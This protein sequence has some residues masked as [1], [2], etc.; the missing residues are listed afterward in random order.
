M[1]VK[2]IP[3]HS[4]HIAV[5]ITAAGHEL[6]ALYKVLVRA[7]ELLEYGQPYEKL[8]S[9]I[10]EGLARQIQREVEGTAEHDLARVS[11]LACLHPTAARMFRDDYIDTPPVLCVSYDAVRT[12]DTP[13][14]LNGEPQEYKEDPSDQV[15]RVIY[16]EK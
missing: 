1:I 12:E 10:A 11:T 7:A 13:P 2:N 14:Q 6:D 9:Q 8:M 3:N 4:P 15:P 16:G 5:K